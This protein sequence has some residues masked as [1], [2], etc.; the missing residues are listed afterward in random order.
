M[1]DR[2]VWFEEGFGC[3]GGDSDGGDICD[4]MGKDVGNDSVM[5]VDD[6]C[7]DGDVGDY[8]GFEN[9]YESDMQGLG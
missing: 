1:R 8:Q 7:Y 6:F 9:R 2:L 3:N 5:M 4:D